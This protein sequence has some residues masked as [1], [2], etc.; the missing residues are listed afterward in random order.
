MN[1]LC[2]YTY[3]LF[4]ELADSGLGQIRRS[5]NLPCK[6]IEYLSHMTTAP[7]FKCLGPWSTWIWWAW[8]VRFQNVGMP[9]YGQ[10]YKFWHSF[11]WRPKKAAHLAKCYSKLAKVLA[12]NNWHAHVL[13]CWYFGIQ[14][15]RPDILILEENNSVWG[16]IQ[17]SERKW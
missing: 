16:A 2:I 6:V 17:L 10:A 11:G 14:P 3:G 13:A 7:E 8:L 1:P 12:K 15:S 4:I 9:K 5:L